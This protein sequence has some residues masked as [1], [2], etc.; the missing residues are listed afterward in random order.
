MQKIHLL[1]VSVVVRIAV[2]QLSFEWLLAQCVLQQA[3]E[4]HRNVWTWRCPAPDLCRLLHHFRRFCTKCLVADS[5]EWA[6]V[7]VA[8]DVFV[9]RK[10][11]VSL[12]TRAPRWPVSLHPDDLVPIVVDVRPERVA[13][14]VRVQHL[15]HHQLHSP[16]AHY[17][18]P[19][20][21]VESERHPAAPI[22]L[23]VN[24]H[25]SNKPLQSPAIL[26][27]CEFWNIIIHE[28]KLIK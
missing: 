27:N 24:M 15:D 22:F 19:T 1:L 13:E 2:L 21:A 6:V 9:A 11:M 28:F 16:N 25:R 7:V 17:D 5:V 12:Q 14:S 10:M 3:M 26:T 23:V 18:T 20:V 8:V 4:T